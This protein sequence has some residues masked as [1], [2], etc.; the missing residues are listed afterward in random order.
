MNP[1]T[2][3]SL[4][5]FVVFDWECPR[6]FEE[7]NGVLEEGYSDDWECFDDVYPRIRAGGG[8]LMT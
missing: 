2:S 4:S 5:C 7:D 8:R 3:L 1:W 6:R